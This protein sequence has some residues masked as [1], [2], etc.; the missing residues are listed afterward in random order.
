VWAQTSGSTTQKGC[1]LV[2]MPHSADM[3][4]WLSHRLGILTGGYATVWAQTSGSTTQQGCKLVVMPHSA[5]MNW[6]LSHRL[7]I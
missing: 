4:W 3:N 5:D 6:W 1:K 7:G 2:V